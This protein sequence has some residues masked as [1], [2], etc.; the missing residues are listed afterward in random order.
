[1]D[2]L[3]EGRLDRRRGHFGLEP[4]AKLFDPAILDFG[5]AV[6]NGRPL[7]CRCR[8]R[9]ACVREF[10]DRFQD[11]AAPFMD[12]AAIAAEGGRGIGQSVGKG[13]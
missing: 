7:R 6:A 5:A 10:H 12:A 2:I 1:M 9:R 11:E 3:L 13:G 4:G 8:R